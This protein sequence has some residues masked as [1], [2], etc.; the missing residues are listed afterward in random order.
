MRILA[1]A[2]LG[3]VVVLVAFK[4]LFLSS[5]KTPPPLVLVHHRAIV[6]H[7]SASAHKIAAKSAKAQPTKAQPTKAKHVHRAAPKLNL[8]P[9]LPVPLRKALSHSRI[10][11]AV[12]YA[13]DVPGD[14]EAVSEARKG[15]HAAH[16]GFTV[17]NVRNEAVARAV[18][19]QVQGASDPAVLVV[20]R[21]GTVAL[22]IDGFVDA[23]AVA[24]AAAN[25]HP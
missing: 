23:A 21:P 14:S 2:G 20:R 11:V 6:H 22:K 5:N 18:A 17:L 25:T 19:R 12:L 1:G 10:V 13:P 24:Q 15:A 4:M 16:V 7:P 8:D 9:T 3:L